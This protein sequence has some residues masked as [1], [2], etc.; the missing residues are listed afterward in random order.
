MLSIDAAR[1]QIAERVL[2]LPPVTLPLGELRGRVLREPLVASEDFPGF[3]RS[4]MDGYAICAEDLSASYTVVG[5]V[6]PGSPPDFEIFP[7]Q[8]ARIFTGGALPKGGGDTGGGAPGRAPRAPTR[9]G[10]ACWG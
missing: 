9:G 3:D 2:P 1:L 8:C 5:E 4:A 10:R 6:R 7:G